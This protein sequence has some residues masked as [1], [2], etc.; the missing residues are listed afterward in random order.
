MAKNRQNTVD[1][2]VNNYNIEFTVTPVEH[3][4]YQ[5]FVT[6]KNRDN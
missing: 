3:P 2:D 5:G 4:R 1:R 6:P